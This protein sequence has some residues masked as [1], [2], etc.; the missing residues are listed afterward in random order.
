MTLLE[1]KTGV[2]RRDITGL[3]LVGGGSSRFGSPKPLA[4]FGA[5]TL[6]ERAW[7]ILGDACAY[8]LAIGKGD[9]DLG[10]SV[11]PDGSAVAIADSRPRGRVARG[12][13]RCFGRSAG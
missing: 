6:A 5:E 13:S 12:T 3:L 7:R 2:A 11:V 9:E 1:Y 4:R 8:R 10:F